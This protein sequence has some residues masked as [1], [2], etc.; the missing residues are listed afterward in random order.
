MDIF[1]TGVFRLNMSIKQIA[2]SFQ[3]KILFKLKELF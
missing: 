1:V 3:E 2:L